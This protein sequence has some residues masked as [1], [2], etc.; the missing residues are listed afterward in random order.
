MNFTP[1]LV[2]PMNSEDLINTIFPGFD[3]TT[4]VD[5]ANMNDT[6]VKEEGDLGADLLIQHPQQQHLPNMGHLSR[7]PNLDTVESPY[8]F[9]VTIPP[10]NSNVV[11]S[12]PKLFIKRNSKMTINVAYHQQIPGEELFVRAMLIF[13][14]PAEMHLPVKRCANHR[15][16]GSV[17]MNEQ[18][19][20]K[21]ANILK[22]NDPKAIYFGDEHGQTFRDRLSVVVPLESTQIDENT[23]KIVQSIGLE[24]GCQNSCSSGINRRPTSIV[25]T[26]E[27]GSGQLIGKSVIEFKVCSCP[28]RDAEREQTELK[29]RKNESNDAFPRGKRPKYTQPQH[30]APPQIIK[31]EPESES[32]SS[33]NNDHQ[34]QNVTQVT[35]GGIGAVSLPSEMMTDVL[36]GL[37]DQV[38]GKMA[39]ESKT[40]RNYQVLE[41]AMKELRKYRKRCD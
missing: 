40:P 25:F 32:D 38:A 6:N 19:A 10:E 41:K 18:M 35:F 31:P 30:Q 26:L 29:K 27:N 34:I 12:T 24:F 1:T 23:N 9:D 15:N 20:S 17:N 36:K 28:K 3:E 33:S 4:Y 39:E 37:F 2:G 5:I 8:D 14:Q 13:S 16:N 11:F 21:E 7:I 22:V